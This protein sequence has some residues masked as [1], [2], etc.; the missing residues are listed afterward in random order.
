MVGLGWVGVEGVEG[1]ME[2]VEGEGEEGGE[3]A[4]SQHRTPSLYQLVPSL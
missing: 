2:G 4:L 1:R 3:D